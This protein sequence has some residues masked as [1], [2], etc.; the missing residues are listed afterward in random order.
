LDV[1]QPHDGPPAHIP[2]T[3]FSISVSGTDP[4]TN[5]T[6]TPAAG[7]G[8][9]I[10]EG[11]Q[12]VQPWVTILFGA[13]P[14][15]FMIL[16]LKTAALTD[17]GGTVEVKAEADGLWSVELSACGIRTMTSGTAT[18]V[19]AASCKG[20]DVTQPIDLAAE[21]IP[22]IVYS[23]PEW[24][25]TFGNGSKLEVTCSYLDYQNGVPDYQS[26]VPAH[27]LWYV[28]SQG[29]RS[30]IAQGLFPGG[31]NAATFTS[32]VDDAGGSCLK[33]TDWW[34]VD[35]ANNNTP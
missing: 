19:S 9:Y 22:G 32:G 27:M 3:D 30:K 14:S 10:E 29:R 6:Y 24:S 11:A 12:A 21:C 1:S 4:C 23:S 15:R 25:S 8:T 18:S 26:L 20:P 13:I 35:S 5:F 17:A 2:L 31:K 28:D 7:G 16:R 34:S 33:S